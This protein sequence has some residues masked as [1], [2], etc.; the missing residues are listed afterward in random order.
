MARWLTSLTLATAVVAPCAAGAET[1]EDALAA[2]FATN[3]NLEEARLGVSAAREDRTQARSAYL[4]AL[5]AAGSYGYEEYQLE[6]QGFFGPQTQE[7]ELDPTNVSAQLTQQLY[8]GGRRRGQSRLASATIDGARQALRSTEQQVLLSAVEAYLSVRR[9]TAV[10]RLNEEHVEGL[11]R[12]LHAAQRRL[13]VGEVSRTDV[14]QAQTRLSGA[15]AQL[16]RARADL[17]G[18]HARY[19]E[20]IGH[21]PVDLAAPTTPLTPPSLDAAVARAETAHPE[22]LRARSNELAAQAR[23]TIERAAL[24]PQVNLVGRYEEADEASRG[25]ERL[26]GSSATAQFSWPLFEGG[27]ARS[28][29]RQS[30][31]N[32]DRAEA[33]V[34]ARRRRIISDVIA[35]WS[36]LRA[37]R[38]VLVAARE[39]VTAAEQALSG[40]ERERG[41]GL[42]DTIDVLNAEEERRNAL[43]GLAQAEANA[44]FAAYA[45]SAATGALSLRALGLVDE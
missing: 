20:I 21:G 41:L 2:A 24:R 42:R 1:I 6:S 33:Q 28:R 26:E 32:A 27:F 18:S 36:D 19:I 38:E 37:S 17:V 30:R 4:P 44:V 8:T 9:D 31:I 35:A 16:A 39:Q 23:V 45:L 12:Q 7:L 40:I 10:V 11:S 22:L 29:V 43:V 15:R 3:P 34:E 13:D 25:Q 5:G 14:S